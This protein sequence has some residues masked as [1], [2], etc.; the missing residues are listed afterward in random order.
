M[1][2][3]IKKL[4]KHSTIYGLGSI[5]GKVVGFLLI[6]LY[7]HYLTPNDYGVLELIDI[8]I[9]V[10]GLFVAMGIGA[11][12][13]RFYYH[14]DDTK[15]KNEVISTA[16]IFVTT[17]AALVVA[18]AISFAD[19]IS[20][21]VFDT[22]EYAYYFQLM[23]VSFLFS[24][25]ASVPESYA[26][27]KQ[28]S[29]LFTSITI[30]TLVLNLA[31]NIYVVAFLKMGVLGIVYVSA[32]MR[33][34]NA[35][36]WLFLTIPRVGISFSF[37]KLKELLKYGMPLIP[38]NIGIFVM[39]F[40]DRFFLS[41]FMSLSAVGIYSLGYKFGFM[42]SILL[43]QPFNR[44]WQAQMFEIAKKQDA[45][46]IFAKMF[47]YFSYVVLFAV[48]GLSVFI[49][50]AIK[51]IADSSFFMAYKF[52]PII[53]LACFFRGTYFFFQIGLLLKKKTKYVGY[54]VS[55]AACLNL[56]LN[57]FFIVYIGT[58]GAAIAALFTNIVMAGFVYFYSQ[59]LYRIDY[60]FGRISKLFAVASIL[61][62]LSCLV[63]IDSIVISML[64][65]SFF[66]LSFP[67]LLFLVGFYTNE[68]KE[69]FIEIKNVVR[70]KVP[71]LKVL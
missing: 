38:A 54:S 34:L 63:N 1:L 46:K 12:V 21:L 45:K 51:F 26:M 61:Y 39:T 49:K 67:F 48:L 69:K 18:V 11:A 36:F 29:A 62:C 5:L 58:I 44:I 65:K 64:V 8:T 41:H 50:D 60:E 24:T 40:A 47:T 52:V 6:P 7:T 3:D 59:K 20:T 19:S 27:A 10:A 53:A 2:E 13:F 31:L 42:I 70:A 25:I 68:E 55:I 30:G 14:Y 56:I 37:H 23:F 28:K 4:I 66:I 71:S 15:D 9:S 22:S 43:I 16:F 32:I 57:Y 17:M 35:A 33:S